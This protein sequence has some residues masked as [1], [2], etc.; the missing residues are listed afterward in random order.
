MISAEEEPCPPAHYALIVNTS[1]F[2][3]GEVAP[4]QNSDPVIP[5]TL[6]PATGK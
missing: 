2:R 5:A 1:S 4:D 3:H 6:I